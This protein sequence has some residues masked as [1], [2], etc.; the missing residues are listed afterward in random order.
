MTVQ[1]AINKICDEMC[2]GYHIKPTCDVLAAGSFDTEVTGIV[3]T[4]IPS[5]EVIRKS[6]EIGA[7]FIISHEPTWFNGNDV[8]DW[9][10]NDSVYLAKKKLLDEHGIS[11]WRFH[12]HMHFGTNIDYIYTGMLDELGWHKYLQADAEQAPWVYEIPETTLKE[13]SLQ[14]KELFEM[15]HIRVVGDAGCVIKRVGLLVGGG[16]LG[17]GREV[18]P[19]EVMERNDLN[20]LICGDITEWTTV[21]YIN[22][23]R[24]LGMN[25]SMIHLGH[26]RTEEPGM[27]HLPRHLKKIIPEIPITFIDAR[28]PYTYF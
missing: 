16:S 1:E 14:L 8:T 5:I 10:E 21:E 17:L 4:F 25:R 19:M 6:I 15:D 27:K 3:T 22:D 18:M 28:E 12:D 9:C 26:E 11:V 2:G 23:A 20:V 13:L 7:N 24:Q